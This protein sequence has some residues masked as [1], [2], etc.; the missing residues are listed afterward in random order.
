MGDVAEEK[1]FCIGDD[2][3]GDAVSVRRHETHYVLKS[4]IFNG[5]KRARLKK[6]TNRSVGDDELLRRADDRIRLHSNNCHRSASS[7]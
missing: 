7:S 3:D 5:G 2:G 6:S 4:D 1:V